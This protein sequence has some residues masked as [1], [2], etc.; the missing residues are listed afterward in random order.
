MS[1]D[2]DLNGELN[3]D[4]SLPAPRAHLDGGASP[5]SNWKPKIVGDKWAAVR[6]AVYTTTYDAGA[7]DAWLSAVKEKKGPRKGG[8]SSSTLSSESK[9]GRVSNSASAPPLVD[10]EDR[11]T[12]NID[13]S[14]ILVRTSAVTGTPNG[15]TD[16]PRGKPR[17]AS[18][19][20]GESM[21]GQAY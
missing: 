13:A 16:K 14:T 7:A 20:I 19:G 8:A 11:M 18:R 1:L 5:S 10:S 3:E 6:Q 15:T 9:A 17:P 21:T 12:N 2:P 4:G